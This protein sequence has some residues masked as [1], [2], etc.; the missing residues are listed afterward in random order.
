ML[1]G[2]INLISGRSEAYSS[3]AAPVGDRY[4]ESPENRLATAT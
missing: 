3:V 1:N 4:V 2:S